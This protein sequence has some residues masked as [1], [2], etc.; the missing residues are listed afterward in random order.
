MKTIHGDDDTH[1][2]AEALS[3]VTGA[4]RRTLE[5]IFRHP[6]AH[7]LEWSAVIGLIGKVGDAQEKSNSEFVFEIAGQR[8]LMRKPHTKDLTSSEVIEVRHFLMQAGLSPEVS[9]EPAAHPNPDAPN[10]L[11]VVDHHGTRIYLVD[12]ASD[13]ASEHVI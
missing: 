13:D 12:V 2:V 10:L 6:S 3:S 9:S 5:A 8:H 4:H 1:T 11:V 7:N